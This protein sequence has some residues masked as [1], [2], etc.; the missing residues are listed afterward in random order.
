MK[1]FPDQFSQP[2]EQRD[3][4]TH[5]AGWSVTP[6]IVC[7]SE[8]LSDQEIAA[9]IA[10]GYRLVFFEYC[11]SFVLDTARRRSPIFLLATTDHGWKKRMRYSLISFFAGWWG[12]PWGLIYTPI[13]IVSNLVGG[14][15]VTSQ[16]KAALASQN[17]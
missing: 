3:F 10:C 16:F 14:C 11:F 6:P 13:V 2:V 4:P 15:D 7:D 17:R 8:D 9:R 5:E 12:V 1:Q